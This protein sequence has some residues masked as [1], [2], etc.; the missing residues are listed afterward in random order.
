MAR[1]KQQFKDEIEPALRAQFKLSSN[2]QTPRISKITLNMGLGEAVANKNVLKTATEDLARIQ[3][4]KS[5][6][7]QSGKIRS[8]VQDPRGLADWRQGHFAARAHV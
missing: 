3:R 2:M 1:L 5:R 8:G 6:Y 7:H 4:P